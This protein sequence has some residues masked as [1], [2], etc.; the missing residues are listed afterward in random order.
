MQELSYGARIVGSYIIPMAI[1]MLSIRKIFKVPDELFRKLL[2]FVLLGA[3]IPFLFAFETWWISAG[4]TAFLVIIIYPI[5]MIAGR[6]PSFSKFVNERKEGEFKSSMVLALGM[7]AVS[8]TV[9]WGGFNDRYLVLACIYAWGVGDAFA[10]LIGKRFGRHKIT[11]KFADS[12]K[13]VEGSFAM[14]VTSALAVYIILSIRGGIESIG[15]MLIAAA[16]AVVC[17]LVELCTKN[18]LDTVTCPTM[19]MAVILP[20]ICILGG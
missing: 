18:G 3:Y 17:M 16:A 1:I 15:C 5:L 12:K 7:M 4:F 2:H 13:S 6:I 8:I 9:C 10:A 19:A 11:W 14:F 20:M